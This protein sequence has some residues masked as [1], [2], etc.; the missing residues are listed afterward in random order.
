MSRIYKYLLTFT[1]VQEIEMPKGAQVIHVG[2]QSEVICIWAI[3]DP[4]QPTERRSFAI[5]A[6]GQPDFDPKIVHHLGSVIMT[7]GALVRHVFEPATAK[8]LR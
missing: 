8:E 1:G 5:L 4:A 2:V 7:G 6:T 3:V